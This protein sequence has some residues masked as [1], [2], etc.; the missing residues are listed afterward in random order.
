MF[1]YSDSVVVLMADDDP[2]DRLMAREAWE[3]AHLKNQLRFVED[4]REL[5]AEAAEIPIRPEVTTYPL[6]E[7]NRALVDL[8][9]SEIDGTGVLVP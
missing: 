9:E 2:D 6:A 3:E 7:A 8:K 4:G 1:K 5:L